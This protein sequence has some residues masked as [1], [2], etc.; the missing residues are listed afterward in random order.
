MQGLLVM[1]PV[2]REGARRPFE[3]VTRLSVT[4]HPGCSRKDKSSRTIPA[5]VN[6]AVAERHGLETLQ[7]R[8]RL[9]L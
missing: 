8:K 2:N 6:F 3:V 7:D 9:Q 1:E 5:E 4:P